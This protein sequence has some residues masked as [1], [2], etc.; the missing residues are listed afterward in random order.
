MVSPVNVFET[1][2]YALCKPMTQAMA[3]HSQAMAVHSQA[4]NRRNP[5]QGIPLRLFPIVCPV[6]TS[7]QVIITIVWN[8]TSPLY[9][10]PSLESILLVCQD[11]VL[12]V[13]RDNHY[14]E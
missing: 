6:I 10:G 12:Q 8:A 14:P 7:R 5:D 4:N 1:V 9:F 3:V 2:L 13:E 11:G